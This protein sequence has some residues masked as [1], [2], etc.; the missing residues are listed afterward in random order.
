MSAQCSVFRG[1]GRCAEMQGGPEIWQSLQDLMLQVGVPHCEW[2]AQGQG[3]LLNPADL[4]PFL[5]ASA[6]PPAH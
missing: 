4:G 1:P 6:P 3:W 2:Q 5:S